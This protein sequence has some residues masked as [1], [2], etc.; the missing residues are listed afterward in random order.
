MIRYRRIGFV[1]VAFLSIFLP[2]GWSQDRPGCDGGIQV[3]TV[4]STN[5]AVTLTSSLE[6]SNG[7]FI[8]EWFGKVIVSETL[9]IAEGTL[10]N[11]TGATG[12]AT[13]DGNHTTQ[14]FVVHG[15]S[16][17]LCFTDILLTNG[18]EDFGGAVRAL[19]QAHISFGGNTTFTANSEWF[20]GAI[21]ADKCLLGRRE[22]YVQQ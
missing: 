15:A 11:I 5:D 17:S 10:V 2:S 19:D 9:T 1:M 7:T 14:L 20:G 4:A 18:Q 13:A 21:F 22:D 8:V 6:C 16:S 3:L 12:D